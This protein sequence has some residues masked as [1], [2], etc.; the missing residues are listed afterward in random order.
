MHQL[1]VIVLGVFSL[2]MVIG[3]AVNPVTGERE[4]ALISDERAIAIGQQQYAPAQQMQGGAYNTDSELSAYVR[5]IG[6][7]LAAYSNTR[8]PYEFV[9]LNHSV[10]NAWALP[11]GK[12]AINRG[13]LVELENE[14]ELAA[15]LGHEIVHAAARH[16]AQ[17][18]ERGILTQGLLLGTAIA[19][20][21]QE[22]GA[23]A[24]QGAQLAAGLVGQKYSR[25]AER[26]AD[27]YGTRFMAQAGYD[28]VGAVTLQETFVRLS[29]Q[30]SGK[31]GFLDQLFASHPASQERVNNNKRLVQNLRKEGFK[32]GVLNQQQFDQAVAGLRSKQDAFQAHDEA[33]A[34]YAKKD[35]DG[36]LSKV[37]QALAMANDEAIFHA[38]RG[39]IRYQQKRLD[40]AVINFDRAIARDGSYFAFHLQRGLVHKA[41]KDS[42][43]AKRDLAHS[44]RLLPTGIAYNALGEIAEQEG[45]AETA[46]K[47]YAQAGGDPGAAGTAARASLVRLELPKQPAKYIHTAAGLDANGKLAVQVQNRTDLVIKNIVLRVEVLQFGQ[48]TSEQLR[49]NELAP[50]VTRRMSL[51]DKFRQAERINVYPL[52]ADL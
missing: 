35:Y 7:S 34:L 29:K 30:S 25:D 42:Q 9:V 3:C 40:D 13:L 4:I 46:Q 52:S 48:V 8:L 45:D 17:R 14:A 15:V 6:A 21:G 32:D 44:V 51:P 33:Q 31:G 5:R 26:E 10:P 50:K 28:P 41:Q 43:A 39:T 36:A 20:G 27:F 19:V 37:N 16:G 38:T 1:R 18:M 47:Y 24:V 11:G 49:I 23:Y 22:Y 12:I 2:V